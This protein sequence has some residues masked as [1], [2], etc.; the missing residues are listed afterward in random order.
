MHDISPISFQESHF[1]CLRVPPLRNTLARSKGKLSKMGKITDTKD[2]GNSS[3]SN[4]D[5]HTSSNPDVIKTSWM[6]KRS[7]LK[8]RFSFSNYKDR[9]FVLTRGTL[10]YYDGADTLKKKE[11]G[12]IVLKDVKLVE[13]VALRDES[14]ANAFQIGYVEKGQEYSLYIQ[15]RTTVATLVT[16]HNNR[17]LSQTIIL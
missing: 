15:V 6:T 3:S 5:H 17:S 2:G 13:H 14:K 4:N 10:I 16:W 9:W 7:Q 1:F 11:K 12:R 8:S